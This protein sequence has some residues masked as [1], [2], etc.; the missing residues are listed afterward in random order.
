VSKLAEAAIVASATA[1]AITSLRI[2]ANSFPD[3][4]AGGRGRTTPATKR[5]GAMSMMRSRDGR[6]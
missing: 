4:G 3:P 6:K 5:P 2:I 1:P